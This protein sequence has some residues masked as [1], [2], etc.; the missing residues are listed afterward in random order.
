MQLHGSFFERFAMIYSG[1]LITQL[2]NLAI[3]YFCPCLSYWGS[4]GYWI[5]KSAIAGSTRQR[6]EQLRVRVEFKI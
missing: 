3:D 5:T 6:Q 1:L 2:V 4:W